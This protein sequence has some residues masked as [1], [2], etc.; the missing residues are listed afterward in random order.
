LLEGLITAVVRPGRIFAT[1][2]AEAA[3]S[4]SQPSTRSASPVG[5]RCAFNKAGSAAMRTWDVTEPFFCDIPVMSRTDTPLPS[6]W[7]AMPMRAPMVMTPV[8]PM[9]VIRTLCRP[10]SLELAGS[11]G[12]AVSAG[13]APVPA[14]PVRRRGFAPSTVTKL[15]Q[16]PFRHE[17][18]TL[19]EDWS[20]VRLTP[21]GVCKGS[22][23]VQFD[24]T[25][26]SPQP[27]HTRSLI[28]TRAGASGIFPFLR[29]RRFS[30]AQTWS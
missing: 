2:S 12:I 30:A 6:R 13:F 1:A 24:W 3:V 26:Q 9:P 16:N 10:A 18:S 15:G 28:T 4:M 5:M 21:S 20:T 19:Q 7:A 22:S 23:E 11:S 17:R 25:P 29:R 8:P 14:V 27:S